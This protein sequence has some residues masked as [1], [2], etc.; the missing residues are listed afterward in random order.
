MRN[1]ITGPCCLHHNTAGGLSKRV[2][3]EKQAVLLVVQASTHIDV[4]CG[5]PAPMDL[6]AEN[7]IHAAVPN[8]T[9]KDTS[10]LSPTARLI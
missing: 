9:T 4:Y 8:A 7:S 1:T 10:N 5:L 2:T 3:S 6:S